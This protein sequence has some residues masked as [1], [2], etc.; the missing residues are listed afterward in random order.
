MWHCGVTLGIDFGPATPQSI[1]GNQYYFNHT[2]AGLAAG[3][4][5]VPKDFEKPELET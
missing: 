2:L 1:H 5:L 3:A 4:L